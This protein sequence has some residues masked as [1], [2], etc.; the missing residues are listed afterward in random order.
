MKPMNIVTAFCLCCL[1]CLI[2]SFPLSAAAESNAP[3]EYTSNTYYMGDVDFDGCVSAADARLALRQSVE[4][5]QLSEEAQYY[6]DYDNNGTI[7]ASDARMILRTSV[8]LEP[9]NYPYDRVDQSP[10]EKEPPIPPEPVTDTFPQEPAREERQKQW[11]ESL[12]NSVS[13]DDLES[14]MYW[15]V[16]KIGVRSW[17]NITETN[18]ADALFER[19]A[20]YGFSGNDLQKKIFFHNGIRGRNIMAVIPTE[21]QYPKIILVMAHYDTA[22]STGGAV[23]NSSGTAALLQLAKRFRYAEQDFGAEL[24]F[25]FTAGEEQGYYG[26]YAYLDALMPQEKERH[27]FVFNIDMA[28]KPNDLYEPGR[29]YYLC[30]STEPVSTDGYHSP[31]AVK[32]IGSAAIDETKTE[33]GY[34]GED[35]YYSPVRAGIHDIVPFRKAGM[36]ALT[37]SWR[38]ISSARSSGADH[39]LAPPFFIHTEYDNMNYFDLASLYN[40]T[41][42][43][44]GAVARLLLPYRPM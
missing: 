13:Y 31:S 33:L 16:D 41:R 18:A 20:S 32:N 1:C 17:W 19:L 5:E 6:A 7:D 27:L 25:L 30:V 11:V 34:L 37:L 40:T 10:E 36:S 9:L 23:D 3:H 21:V 24:R 8:L 2:C 12:I 4:S 38:C 29:R 14:N 22:R 42:L 26:A 39:D 35:G 15:L 43:C 44:A 28:G